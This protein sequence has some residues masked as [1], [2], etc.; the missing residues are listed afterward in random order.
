MQHPHSSQRCNILNLQPK[1][2]PRVTS[3][4]LWPFLF[5]LPHSTIKACF[6]SACQVLKQPE[7]KGNK[8]KLMW[9]CHTRLLQR[10]M[11]FL[12]N[13]P[14]TLTH[15]HTRMPL[16]KCHKHGLVGV[17]VD[18]KANWTVSAV[19]RT[20]IS[21]RKMQVRADKKSRCLFMSYSSKHIK[22][23]IAIVIR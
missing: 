3:F 14:L 21:Y 9:Q 15:T 20:I 18:H 4:S 12:L 8:I 11:C 19:E 23:E 1:L 5:N 6:I 2:I 22:E 13:L 10:I 7:E 16:I 17:S